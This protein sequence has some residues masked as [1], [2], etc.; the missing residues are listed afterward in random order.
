MML[1]QREFIEKVEGQNK[2]WLP[3][4]QIVERTFANMEDT[5]ATSQI[6]QFC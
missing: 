1:T 3:A 2:S 5:K 4:R 6:H